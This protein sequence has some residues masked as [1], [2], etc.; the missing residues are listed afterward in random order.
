MWVFKMCCTHIEIQNS[1]TNKRYK[2]IIVSAG[3]TVEIDCLNCLVLI[4]TSKAGMYDLYACIGY[5]SADYRSLIQLIAG[6]G[7]HKLAHADNDKIVVTNGNATAASRV[8]CVS[9]K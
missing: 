3:G 8:Y 4:V 7:R 6:Q 1:K 2:E 9:L 5:G